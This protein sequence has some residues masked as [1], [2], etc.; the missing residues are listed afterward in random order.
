MRTANRSGIRQPQLLQLATKF[1]WLP[2]LLKPALLAGRGAES[3]PASR[4][5]GRAETFCVG[6][7]RGAQSPAF[8]QHVLVGQA[9][10]LS[11]AS[12]ER[13]KRWWGSGDH[14]QHAQRRPSG[15]PFWHKLA[16]SLIVPP[17]FACC[18]LWTPTSAA[19]SA[20][21]DGFNGVD[22]VLLRNLVSG[23]L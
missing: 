22:L 15:W 20:S 14:S 21:A 4:H 9:G 7:Q 17:V 18:W 16:V 12:W 5:E 2:G 6:K 19:C 3:T 1:S 8:L 13:G 10:W 23:T 11:P